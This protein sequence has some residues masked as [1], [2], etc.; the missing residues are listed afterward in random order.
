MF[1]QVQ[2]RGWQL[3]GGEPSRSTQWLGKRRCLGPVCWPSKIHHCKLRTRWPCCHL[4]QWWHQ[5]ALGIQSTQR[6]PG[7]GLAS[8]LVSY[9]EHSCSI[10]RRLQGNGTSNTVD[11]FNIMN[12]GASNLHRHLISWLSCLVL[13]CFKHI[14]LVSTKGLD[15]A[16]L[17]RKP[18]PCLVFCWLK[19]ILLRKKGLDIA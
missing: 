7:C 6:I 15:M 8:E 10:W 18:S 13:V 1:S 17:R 3:G 9:G 14:L 4:E 16:K 2:G 5:R 12:L 19:E 11:S